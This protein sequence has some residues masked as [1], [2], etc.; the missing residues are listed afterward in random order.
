MRIFIIMIIGL[1]LFVTT[2]IAGG[3][4]KDDPD[5]WL[6]NA[7]EMTPKDFKVHLKNTKDD[8]F[9]WE[10]EHKDPV[11]WLHCSKC[12]EFF[13]NKEMIDEIVKRRNGG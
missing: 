5:T 8:N 13:V 3:V 10:C 7:L 2:F 6:H 11:L 9:E 12:N 4:A 1:V